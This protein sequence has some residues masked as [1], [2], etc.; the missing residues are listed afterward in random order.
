MDKKVYYGE[1]TLKHWIE[2][3]LNS[4]LELPPYQ[5]NF[6][7]KKEQV[8]EFIKGVKDGSF[9]PPV[10]IGVCNIEAGNHNLILDGQQRLSSILLAYY[11]VYPKENAFQR[12][13]NELI[14]ADG[15]AEEDDDDDDDDEAV[16]YLDWSL[17]MF[18]EKGPT[19]QGVRVSITEQQYERIDY[20]V[21][22]SFFENNYIPFSFIIPNT[23]NETE[24][25]EFFSSLF[26]NINIL[27][28]SLSLFESRQSL[29]FLKKE[30]QSF[31]N[32]ECC[33][34]LKIEL[35]TKNQAYD[36]VR[37]ISILS[38]YKK[39]QRFNRLAQNY[40]SKME[41]YYEEYIYAV[42]NN[43]NDG[44]FTQ[45]SN[46][47]PNED[48]RPRIDKL[49]ETLRNLKYDELHFTSIIDADV[50][51]F[52]LVYNV[53]IEGKSID[54]NHK[55]ELLE[56]LRRKI[57]HFKNNPDSHK[58]SPSLLKHM[59]KRV[60]ESLKIFNRYAIRPA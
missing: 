47:F 53:V 37:T 56:K 23:N 57:E 31:F 28:T 54:Y 2:L 12:N 22:Q 38:Q 13:V 55:E 58:S 16:E 1:Y 5:R 21:D 25:I 52:G 35:T 20:G 34:S 33:K 17:R 11:G 32:P 7:W 19:E 40:K 45:F 51:M 42:V 14:M 24:Q 29:Y 59:R 50:Y 60:E 30:L 46:I 8:K 9:I 48:F 36:F 15:V 4:N 18:A 49:S 39:E 27:G 26:R 41:K 43:R 6:V 10:T 44:I 3:L